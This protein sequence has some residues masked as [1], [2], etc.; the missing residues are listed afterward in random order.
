MLVPIGHLWRPSI[1]RGCASKLPRP[2]AEGCGEGKDTNATSVNP[3]RKRH[4]MHAPTTS[5]LR[6]E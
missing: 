6:P 1:T 3:L 4:Q 2:E 5:A